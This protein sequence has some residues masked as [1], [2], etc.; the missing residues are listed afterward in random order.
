MNE[1]EFAKA[2]AA[3]RNEA[4]KL[5]ERKQELE[6]R[7]AQEQSRAAMEANVPAQVGSFLQDFQG[8]DP[9]LQKAQLQTILKAIQIWND[10][11][12]EL[13]FRG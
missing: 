3:A 8:L 13:E 1:A 2:N 5:E 9:R 6:S 11:R 12:I 10:G 4:A 7:L